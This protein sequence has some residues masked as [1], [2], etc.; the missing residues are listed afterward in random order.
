M[1]GFLFGHIQKK[2]RV[3]D[4][5]ANGRPMGWRHGLPVM[6]IALSFTRCVCMCVCLCVCVC[7][8]VCALEYVCVCVYVYVY[9]YACVFIAPSFT[10]CVCVCVCVCMRG[11]MYVY[12]CAYN[13]VNVFV[14]VGV[15][16]P[17]HKHIYACIDMHTHVHIHIHAYIHSAVIR[18]V[19]CVHQ[20]SCAHACC[21]VCVS[22]A[23]TQND[24]HPHTGGDFASWRQLF[25]CVAHTHEN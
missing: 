2:T 6:A 23:H 15:C 22:H 8:C 25:R 4:L 19:V 21:Y 13:Y 18:K 1:L 12:V 10:R 5:E 3:S 9:K 7:V 17:T 24:A 16:M 14:C 11:S 20:F